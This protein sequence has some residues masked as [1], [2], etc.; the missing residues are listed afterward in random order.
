[1]SVAYRYT[2]NIEDAK[3]AH[4][5][6]FVAIFTNLRSYDKERGTFKQWITSIC[7]REALRVIR[8]QH[9]ILQDIT[10]PQQLQSYYDATL[11]RLTLEE[12]KTKI[13]EMKP[14]QRVIL[15]LFYFEEYT[16]QE[17]AALLDIKEST[18]RSRLFRAK[19]DLN[20]IWETAENY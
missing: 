1:M 15:N 16:H 12:V 10:D 13:S 18:S 7:V 19:K 6:T 11:D 9:K 3:D 17:I 5:N 2:Q 4:Q 14:E 8:K 20:T